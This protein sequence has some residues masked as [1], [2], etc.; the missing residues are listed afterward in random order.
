M[1][2]HYL[3]PHHSSQTYIHSKIV[4]KNMPSEFETLESEHTATTSCSD[5]SL[6]HVTW[7]VSKIWELFFGMDSSENGRGKERRKDDFLV[8]AYNIFYFLH[9]HILD[10]FLPDLAFWP[11]ACDIVLWQLHFQSFYWMLILMKVLWKL[12]MTTFIIMLKTIKMSMVCKTL[13]QKIK[14]YVF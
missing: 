13:T 12:D 5:K 9:F 11:A 7:F 8:L 10:I 6:Q 2:E 1:R 4:E 14:D 3:S